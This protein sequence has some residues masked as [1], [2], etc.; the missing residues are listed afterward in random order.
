MH[1]EYGDHMRVEDL[2]LFASAYACMHL[3]ERVLR[4]K[5]HACAQEKARD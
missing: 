4:V 3:C 5:A 1:A 2:R